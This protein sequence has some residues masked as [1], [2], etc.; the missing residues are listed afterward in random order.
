MIK[1]KINKPN[2]IGVKRVV[3]PKRIVKAGLTLGIGFMVLP[4]IKFNEAG[5]YEP[6]KEKRK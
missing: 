2:W 4:F 3:E 1:Q 5:K 6:F